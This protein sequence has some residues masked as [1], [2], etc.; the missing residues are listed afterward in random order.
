MIRISCKFSGKFLD[1][2]FSNV[3]SMNLDWSSKCTDPY[4]NFLWVETQKFVYS[5]LKVNFGIAEKYGMK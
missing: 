3:E 5:N 1:Y 2:G 4:K